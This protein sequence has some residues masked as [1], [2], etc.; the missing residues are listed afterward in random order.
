M[1]ISFYILFMNG[2]K[3]KLAGE[4]DKSLL[5]ALDLCLSFTTHVFCDIK[6]MSVANSFSCFT[7]DCHCHV[8]RARFIKEVPLTHLKEDVATFLCDRFDNF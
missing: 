2:C 1:E 6:S 5:V 3:V 8:T 7:A 4:K